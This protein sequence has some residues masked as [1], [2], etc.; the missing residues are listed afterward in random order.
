VVSIVVEDLG[1]VQATYDVNA[2]TKA[3]F[4]LELRERLGRFHFLVDFRRVVDIDSSVVGCG[5]QE[6][7]LWADSQSPMLACFLA[8]KWS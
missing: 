7:A 6:L 4:R 3:A 2:S 5:G 1:G 8:W